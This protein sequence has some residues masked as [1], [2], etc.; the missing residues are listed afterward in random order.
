MAREG[1]DGAVVYVGMAG[2]RRAAAYAGG[3]PSTAVAR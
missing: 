3:S 2:E 1:A